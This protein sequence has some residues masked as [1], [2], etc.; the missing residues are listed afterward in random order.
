[1][2]LATALARSLNTVSAQLAAEVGP[3]AVAAT[4]HRLGIRSELVATPSIALGTSEVTPLEMTAAFVP[5]SN[6]GRGV[7]PHV[8]DRIMTAGGDILYERTGG[9]P[10][11]VI[12][13]RYVAMMNAMMQQ[14][15][16]NGTGKNAALPN[17]PVAG[18]T[19]TSQDFRDAWFIG[20][21]G[22]LTTGVW[23]GNDDNKPTKKASGSNL[24][25]M[26]WN[27]F[28]SAAL[29]GVAVADLPGRYQIGD[30]GNFANAAAA[31]RERPAAGAALRRLQRS[32]RRAG[33]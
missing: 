30:G 16:Q 28:M 24:P 2:T 4:A 14:V 7:I 20:Y 12:D 31:G 15:V 5:F 19:G 25:A 13:P 33:R 9:G 22:V 26:A 6:G 10:G 3:Q 29:T 27:R 21:T 32:A 1:M 11:Q 8:I 18:K 23:F 17:W